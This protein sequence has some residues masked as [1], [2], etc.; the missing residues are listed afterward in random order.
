M[1]AT[2]C[3]HVSTL[4]AAAYSYPSIYDDD[5][6]DDH[7][8]D[9]DDIDDQDW[10][11]IG[12]WVGDAWVARGEVKGQFCPLHRLPHHQAPLPAHSIFLF[13]GRNLRLRRRGLFGQDLWSCQKAREDFSVHIPFAT[14]G[15]RRFHK[16]AR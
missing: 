2:N 4:V 16:A 7:N 12:K 14:E 8:D 3:G 9:H 13:L 10:T 5:D 6:D 15:D 1:A 11:D